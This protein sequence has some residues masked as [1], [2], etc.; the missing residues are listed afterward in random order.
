[1]IFKRPNFEI[2]KCELFDVQNSPNFM[3]DILKQKEQL[4][5]FAQLQIP[6]GFQVINSGTNSNINLP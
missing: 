2:R 6:L 1:M 4:Y 3:G 5:L